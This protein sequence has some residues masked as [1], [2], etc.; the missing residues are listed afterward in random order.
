MHSLK[1]ALKDS[2]GKNVFVAHNL[3]ESRPGR[4]G[5][6]TTLGDDHLEINDGSKTIYVPYTS[7]VALQLQEQT[8]R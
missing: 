7:I 4:S 8:G 3:A 6:L 1:T 2:V 5:R